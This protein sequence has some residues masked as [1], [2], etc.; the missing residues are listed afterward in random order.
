MKKFWI[1]GRK[2]NNGH[3]EWKATIPTKYETHADAV[4]EASNRVS[5]NR[6]TYVVFE[7][8]TMVEPA[9]TPVTVTPLAVQ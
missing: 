3:I 2:L 5:E 8:V 9:V 7:A 4:A 6:T 1:I